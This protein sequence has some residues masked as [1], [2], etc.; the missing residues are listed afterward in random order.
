SEGH[1]WLQ[2][3]DD[4]QQCGTPH[5]AFVAESGNDERFCGPNFGW[6][7]RSKPC[8]GLIAQYPDDRMGD[9]IKSDA[10]A[11]NV[12]VAAEAFSPKVLRD[13][14]D[15]STFFFVRQEISAHH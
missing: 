12:R 15:V 13:Q 5:H 6:R 9:S 11:D 4:P 1:A 3:P 2:S 10:A 7:L 14:G 8:G